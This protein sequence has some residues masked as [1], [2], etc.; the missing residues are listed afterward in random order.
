M[1]TRYIIAGILAGVAVSAS[2]SPLTPEQA[3]QRLNDSPARHLK[4]IS[5]PTLSM[6]V[7]PD[8][9][10][11]AL[12]VFDRSDSQ[13]YL[14]VSADDCA[15]PLLGY[16]DSG[17]FD[18]ASLPPQLAWWLDEYARKITYL[19]EHGARKAPKGK[20]SGQEL[21]TI[22]PLLTTS[23]N[24]LTPY[25][26]LCPKTSGAN[27]AT[28]CVATALAM[29]MKHFNHPAKG[30][31]E[32]TYTVGNEPGYV[33]GT[34]SLDFSQVEFDWDNMLDNY[35]TSSY[36]DAQATAVARLMQA[37]GYGSR[38]S[39]GRYTS[40][41]TTPDQ[42]NALI[43]YFDYDKSL[44]YIVRWNYSY[45]EWVKIL[46]SNLEKGYPII[47]GG[48]GPFAGG[49][50]FV[51]DGYQSD[52]Y[53]HFNWGWGGMSNGYYLL[54]VLDPADQGTGGNMGGFSFAEDAVVNIH[55]AQ[56]GS[57]APE[58]SL[59][60]I[61]ILEGS[62]SGNTLTI[63]G[64]PYIWMGNYEY[65]DELINV[66][67]IVESE[68]LSSPKYSTLPSF[69]RLELP[70]YAGF[71]LAKTPLTVNLGSLNL[72]DG[73]YTVT[74]AS[75]DLRNPSGQWRPVKTMAGY[76]NFITVV[77]E[78]G[79]FR[80]EE[81]KVKN[82]EISG[83]KL[84]S[85]FYNH[86]P[87]KLSLT[88]SNNTDIQL[89]RP[90]S[91]LGYDEAENL[92]IQTEAFMTT[93][94]PGESVERELSL[95][96]MSAK[97]V[98]SPTALTLYFYDID[99]EDF[100]KRAPEQAELLP[101]PGNPKTECSVTM[102]GE[103]ENAA[104]WIATDPKDVKAQVAVTVT[105]GY[106]DYPV[107]ILV[108]EGEY[109]GGGSLLRVE[110][111]PNEI[112]EG[113]TATTEFSLDISSFAVDKGTYYLTPIYLLDGKIMRLHPSVPFTVDTSAGISDIITEPG[114]RKVMVYDFAGNLLETVSGLTEG[115][116]SLSI[117][118][119]SGTPLIIVTITADGEVKTYKTIR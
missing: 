102:Q 45:D 23:W 103:S 48:V 85:P 91:I 84:L 9:E 36:N 1:K 88:I 69:S 97:T 3:L 106:F 72:P 30:Q 26:N 56:P 108:T 109:N 22:A 12:Y 87:V 13:G 40:S 42:C 58:A 43:N 115:E 25:N 66:G 29:V 50:S 24:Q 54:D 74:P 80:V 113:E 62:V 57:L 81:S 55:P 11:P 79:T 35:E 95:T 49:H 32:I 16:T 100:Y 86:L 67:V 78:D 37:C 19:R 18:S 110:G 53:F 65:F 82:I 60:I 52:G 20:A 5:T 14:V 76:P 107:V 51:C 31:G 59:S 8:S 4:G 116:P 92:V 63:S 77:K 7:G 70:P 6:K 17:T 99:A 68:S 75:W 34:F 61:G 73:T 104:G 94:N 83:F 27:C 46:H 64:D 71:Y 114:I 47:Y 41:A 101:Y 15:A 105:K 2:A 44:D 112:F 118:A 93:L 21:S 89:S 96:T 38:M 39:Y 33:A 119:G 117:P 111:I 28:G 10:A 98:G 90:I